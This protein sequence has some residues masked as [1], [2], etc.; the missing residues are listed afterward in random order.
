MSK[1]YYDVAAVREALT[2]VVPSV[3]PV[4]EK[5]GEINWKK[6]ADLMDFMIAGGA[7]VLLLTYGDSLVSALSIEETVKF[8]ELMADV[9]A[10]RVM[11]ISCAPKMTQK[12]E[13]AFAERMRDKGLDVHIPMFNDWAGSMDHVLMAE[14]F[15]QIGK[16]MPVM[17][18]SAMDGG[19]LPHSLY[20]LVTPE[21]GIVAVKDDKPMPY[22]RELGHLIRDKFAFLSG[23]T[24][25]M[26]LEEVPYGADGYLSVFARCFPQV[27]QEFWKAYTSGD[28]KE[29][30]RVIEVYELPV[31]RMWDKAHFDA[32]MHAMQELAGVGTRWRR[33]PYS[34]LNDGQMEQ[35]ADMLKGLKLI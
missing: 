19:G 26:F 28:I 16:I 11:T 14:C 12:E 31:Q 27:G 30:A 6:T 7:K 20:P 24:A 35:V 10:G 29:A 17:L 15:R 22:G 4:F 1:N 18:L 5:N 13:I 34:S 32:V 21:D 8:N 25:S 2:S 9:A 23:G 33:A 3:N